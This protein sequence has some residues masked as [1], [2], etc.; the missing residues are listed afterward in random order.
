MNAAGFTDVRCVG[1]TGV[2]TSKYT[3]GAHFTAVKTAE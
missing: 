1:K 2:K 3:V